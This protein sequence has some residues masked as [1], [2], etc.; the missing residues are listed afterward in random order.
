MLNMDCQSVGTIWR[1]G[2]VPH[3]EQGSWVLAHALMGSFQQLFRL[4]LTKSG[5]LFLSLF[6]IGLNIRFGCESERQCTRMSRTQLGFG[7]QLQGSKKPFSEIFKHDLA[8]FFG[9][10]QCMYRG[11]IS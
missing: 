4:I 7:S 1:N 10:A 8:T 9:V 6:N 11:G 5:H 3:V 2:A